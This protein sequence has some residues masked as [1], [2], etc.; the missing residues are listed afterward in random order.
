MDNEG[1]MHVK[2]SQVIQLVILSDFAL[3]ILKLYCYI[4]LALELFYIPVNFPFY[5]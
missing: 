5:H 2:I 4:C 1:G 3:H